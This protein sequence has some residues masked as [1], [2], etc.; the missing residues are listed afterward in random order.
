MVQIMN[1]SDFCDCLRALRRYSA[2]E[3]TMYTN[4]L[5]FGNTP[6]MELTE[7]LQRAMC[8]FNDD[9]S[10]D[11]KLGFDWIISWTSD[12]E[13]KFMQTRHGRTWKLDDAGILY[14]FL[15]FMN[16]YGWEEDS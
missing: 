5:D 1:K 7:K 6:I 3:N 2:W 8:G 15:V 12:P 13:P 9:W 14:D 4:G 16:E 11:K 10:Y